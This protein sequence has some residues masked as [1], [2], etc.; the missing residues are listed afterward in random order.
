MQQIVDLTGKSILIAGASSGIGAQ[1]ARLCSEAGARVILVARSEDKLAD[2]LGSL[3]GE[4]HAICPFDFSR[5]EAI[6]A[7]VGKLIEECGPLDGFVH[8]VGL[9]RRAVP[10]RVLRPDALRAEMDIYFN[11]FV[12]VV[13]CVT[14]RGCYNP[15]MSIVGIS[16]VFSQ[17]GTT[18]RTAYCASKAALNA[19]VRSMARELAPNGIRAN[20]VCPGLIDTERLSGLQGA[21][22]NGGAAAELLARQYLGVGQP[23]DIANVV[24]FLLSEASR[25]ITGTAID[26]DGGLL[27]N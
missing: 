2:V 11:S 19:A 6:E 4:G 8:S 25:M 5:I 21:V 7:F 12:E 16:S 26:A 23:G 1:T 9:R 3:R 20:V 24:V 22:G 13:R 10:L 27:S 15:G 14:R 18:A 17:I